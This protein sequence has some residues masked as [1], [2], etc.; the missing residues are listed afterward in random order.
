MKEK[1]LLVLLS[2]RDQYRNVALY[3]TRLAA[4][5]DM[6]IHYLHICNANTMPFISQKETAGRGMFYLHNNRQTHIDIAEQRLKE[7]AANVRKKME[8]SP[9]ITYAV[10]EGSVKNIIRKYTDEEN[11]G[12]ILCENQPREDLFSVEAGA[13]DVIRNAECPVWIIPGNARY[14]E[15]RHLLYATDY[16]S[17]DMNTLKQLSKLVEKSKPKIT[18]LHFTEDKSFSEELKTK[19]FEDKVRS[20]TGHDNIKVKSYV[21]H[22]DKISKLLDDYA[23]SASADLIVIL[24]KNK[25]FLD[26]FFST[27]KDVVTHVNVPVLVFHGEQVGE[28]A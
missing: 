17:K 15:F 10:E 3:A 9:A 22:G 5:L 12:M 13:F 21:N 19:G 4:D 14:A 20:E 16:I 7:L 1:K 25:Y 11:V 26:H 6:K 18:A 8:I 2:L 24:K 28:P 23:E 27:T